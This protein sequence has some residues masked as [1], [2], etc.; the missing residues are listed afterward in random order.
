[1]SGKVCKHC[2]KYKSKRLFVMK[3]KS[4]DGMSNWCKDCWSRR[5]RNERRNPIS[6]IRILRNGK[7]LR[8]KLKESIVKEYGGKC[9]LCGNSDIRVLTIDHSRR[10]GS[11]HRKKI[12]GRKNYCGFPFYSWLKRNGFPKNLGLR[13]LCG[14]C[15]I[16]SYY[17]GKQFEKDIL[18][19]RS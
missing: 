1:M 10:N 4:K 5:A 3:S 12:S 9:R 7:K 15:Q 17:Y 11:I 2:N 18:R 13:L 16:G 19:R 8:M 14:S 6:R